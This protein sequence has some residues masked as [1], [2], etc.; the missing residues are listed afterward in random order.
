[1]HV[2]TQQGRADQVAQAEIIQ[3]LPGDKL[4]V[5]INACNLEMLDWSDQRDLKISK[6]D[7]VE[8][9]ERPL[10][11]LWVRIP[12]HLYKFHFSTKMP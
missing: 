1:M 12:L 5:V 6:V 8:R 11:V 2:G 3:A 7:Q 10:R 9:I 4:V